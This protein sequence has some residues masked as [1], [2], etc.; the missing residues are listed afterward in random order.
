M[1]ARSCNAQAALTGFVGH[2]EDKSL[3]PLPVDPRS[4]WGGASS[5]GPCER[6][7]LVPD[8]L[9][10]G[11]CPGIDHEF[12]DDLSCMAHEAPGDL[13]EPPPDRRD[14]V[15]GP[16]GWTGEALEPDEQ[17]VGEHPNPEEDRVWRATR[18]RACAP[19]RSRA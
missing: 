7:T 4:R 9:E 16:R 5:G 19:A 13:D 17:V 6:E 1:S 15:L 14:R 2:R 3:P 10:E 12:Q 18:H 11:E 8:L